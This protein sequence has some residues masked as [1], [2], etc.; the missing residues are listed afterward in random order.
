MIRCQPLPSP[1]HDPEVQEAESIRY[2]PT[3]FMILPLSTG[4]VAVLGHMRDLH[5][6]VDTLEEAVEASKTIPFL[7]WRRA[8]AEKE[9]K[10]PNILSGIDVGSLDL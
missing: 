2:G 10:R 4:R 7:V 3:A 1:A 5:A 6:I 8:V 9:A